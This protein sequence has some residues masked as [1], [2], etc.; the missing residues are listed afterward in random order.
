[1]PFPPKFRRCTIQITRNHAASKHGA[2]ACCPCCE[3]LLHCGGPYNTAK[4]YYYNIIPCMLE[5]Y[6]YYIHLIVEC[7]L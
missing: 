6:L 4:E 2:D 7:Y 5:C 3:V 1:M